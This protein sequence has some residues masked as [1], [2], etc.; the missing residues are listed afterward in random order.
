MQAVAD[1]LSWQPVSAAVS[2]T[3]VA[4]IRLAWGR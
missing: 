2:Y 3:P 1:I 4:G